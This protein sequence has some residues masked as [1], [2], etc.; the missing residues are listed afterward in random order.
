M[1]AKK[2]VVEVEENEF[3]K[4]L[5]VTVDGK[6]NTVTVRN[7]IQEAAFKNAGFKEKE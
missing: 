5:V 6:E 1:A 4:V 7:D 3:P 2:E